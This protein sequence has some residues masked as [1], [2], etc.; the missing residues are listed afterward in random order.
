MNLGEAMKRRCSVSDTLDLI[1]TALLVILGAIGLYLLITIPEITTEHLAIGVLAA[2]LL[3]PVLFVV[4][5]GLLEWSE[6]RTGLKRLGPLRLH[7]ERRVA[8]CRDGNEIPFRDLK[9]FV[10]P[11][12]YGYLVCGESDGSRFLVRSFKTRPSARRYVAELN[13]AIDQA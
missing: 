12:T 8:R 10:Q 2:M 3:M 11:H 13:A 4:A 7:H 5:L 1:V 6:F 9:L